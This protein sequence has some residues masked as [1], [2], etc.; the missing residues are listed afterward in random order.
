M[1][2]NECVKKQEICWK[3]R[4]SHGNNTLLKLREDDLCNQRLYIFWALQIY[5]NR[6]SSCW[7]SCQFCFE[8]FFI[9]LKGRKYWCV[10]AV[11]PL[12]LSAR[13]L[14]FGFFYLFCC[15]LMYDRGTFDRQHVVIQCIFF[16]LM[17]EVP[18]KQSCCYIKKKTI[19]KSTA[20][21]SQNRS[22][23]WRCGTAPNSPSWHSKQHDMHSLFRFLDHWWARHQSVLWIT[24]NLLSF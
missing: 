15:F 11:C 6:Q 7:Q 18:A 24:K 17:W 12:P 4:L 9:S 8:I 23:R 5:W 19:K 14:Y 1:S 21:K 22:H 3:Q 20:I 10:Y 13:N 16:F 2:G